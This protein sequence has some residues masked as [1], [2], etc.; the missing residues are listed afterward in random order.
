M[1]YAV[2]AYGFWGLLPIYWK[3][4][5]GVDPVEIVCHRIFWSVFFL[6]GLLGWQGRWPEL[7][8]LLQPRAV[9]GLG[10]TATLLAGNWGLYIYGVNTDRVVETSLGYFINPLVNVLLGVI[11]L[12]ETL[13]SW[14]WLAVGLAGLGVSFFVW[15]SGSIPWIALGLAVSFACYGLGR[16]LLKVPALAGLTLETLLL[17]PLAL[18]ILLALTAQGQSHW[19]L[20]TT[21]LLLGCGLVTALPL[22]WFNQA[23]ERLSLATLGFVQY[24][25]PSIQLIL[26]VAL[27]SEPFTGVHALSFS[28]IWLALGIYSWS[29]WQRRQRANP[30]GNH[31]SPP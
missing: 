30:P 31:R 22:L 27:Y 5:Q 11:C 10:L 4:L 1:I 9:L 2:L 19:G 24:L 25:S 18:G 8:M 12:G 6:L 26:G 16:K 23:A 28:L 17:S 7:T 3:L 21:V 14:G 20:G 13:G 29:S 15:Q